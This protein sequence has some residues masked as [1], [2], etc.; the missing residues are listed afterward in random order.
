MHRVSGLRSIIWDNMKTAR[1]SCIA[2][3]RNRICTEKRFARV[4][5]WRYIQRHQWYSFLRFMRNL[6]TRWCAFCRDGLN[7]KSIYPVIYVA[8]C[9]SWAITSIAVSC[10]GSFVF[11]HTTYQ[12]MQSTTFYTVHNNQRH[13]SD[14]PYARYPDPGSLMETRRWCSHGR[15]RAQLQ[16]GHWS[17]LAWLQ[18][19]E[20][21][22]SVN[23][24]GVRVASLSSVTSTPHIVYALVH[25]AL[26]IEMQ[27]FLECQGSAKPRR[28]S[29]L[30]RGPRW[31]QYDYEVPH[32]VHQATFSIEI[33]I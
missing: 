18:N 30:G 17:Q 7:H 8:S 11:Q 14:V 23:P 4:P 22:H 24:A 6:F 9:A 31:V 27:D 13:S 21:Q 3:M 20:R 15:P 5:K 10:T 19:S 29:S 33:C 32:W 16:R 1:N 12:A 26:I 25:N 28:G 2:Y